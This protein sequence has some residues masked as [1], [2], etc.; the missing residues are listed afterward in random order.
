M[1]DASATLCD[2]WV[3]ATLYGGFAGGRFQETQSVVTA[4]GEVAQG[5]CWVTLPTAENGKSKVGESVDGDW[6]NSCRQA[7]QLQSRCMN[8]HEKRKGTANTT[9]TSRQGLNR[10]ATGISI[11]Q[12]RRQKTTTT[13]TTTTTTI[14][15]AEP[16]L[17]TGAVTLQRRAHSVQER[18]SGVITIAQGLPRRPSEKGEELSRCYCD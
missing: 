7:R 5:G 3:V 18:Q 13:T 17:L 11:A 16:L 14:P 8:A 1:L 12:K 2:G 15:L 6:E 10:P 9:T 4:D